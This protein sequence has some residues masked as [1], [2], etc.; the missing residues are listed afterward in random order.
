M[1]LRP[2]HAAGSAGMLALLCVPALSQGFVDR[3]GDV[4]LLHERATGFDRLGTTIIFD[5]LQRGIAL[6]DIDGDDDLDVVCCG[7]VLENT[8]LRNDGGVFTDVSGAAGIEVGELD[9]APALADFDGDGDLDLAIGVVE[10][11]GGLAAVPGANRFYRNDG[12]GVFEEITTLTATVGGGHTVAHLWSDLDRDGLLDLLASEMFG[13][14]NLVYRN[15][16]DG[17]F[18]EVGAS[19]GLDAA[20]MTHVTGLLDVD[21][22]G[23]DD[24]L[25]GNDFIAGNW[26]LLPTNTGDLHLRGRSDGTWLDVSAGSGADLA[27]G[28]RGIAI[29][30]VDYDGAMDVYKTDV[31][32]NHLLI[33]QGWPGGGAWLEQ[34]DF[35]G[36]AADLVPDPFAPPATGRAIGW[37]AVFMDF[38]FDL[39]LDLFL[40]NGQ[41]P[42]IHPTLQ[43]SPRGQ[44]NF[45]WTGDGPGSSFTFTDETAALGLLDEVDDRALAV[46]DVDDDGDVDILIGPTAGFLRYFENQIDPAGQGWL[47]VDPVCGTSAPGGF[48]VKARFTDSLGFVHE[49][50]IGQD[51]ATASQHASSAYF[52]LGNETSV[53]L[54]VEFPSGVTLSL[55]A[56]APN[57]AIAAVE[58]EIV[59]PNRR[60]MPIAAAGPAPP[61]VVGPARTLPVPFD[62]Q[63]A[64][65]VRVFAHDQA[66]NA[67]GDTAVVT[68]DVPG[69]VPLTPVT[70]VQGNEFLRLFSPPSTPGAFRAEVT[71]DGWTVGI[72]PRVHLFDPNDASG[73]TA[74]VV[75]T[76][77]RAASADTFTVTVAPKDAAGIALGPG[78]PLGFA[79]A[80]LTPLAGP[81][82]LGDGRYRATFPAP[83]AAGAHPIAVTLDDVP[84]GLGLEVEAAG[85]PD[86]AFTQLLVDVPNEALSASPHQLKLKAVPR[87][88]NGF[89]LGPAADVQIGVST[90]P[91]SAP[92]A[93]KT[94]T[95]PAGQPDGEFVFVLEKPLAFPPVSA[96]GSFTLTVEGVLLS[97]TPFAF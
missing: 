41:T 46:G 91:G 29:G 50:V 55:P 2:P 96:S 38:D 4:N 35:Y 43:F 8:V 17:T 67:L 25:V 94:G 3:T 82:D 84:L 88:V 6:G 22:D 1:S 10:S 80:G 49:R 39:W 77:V 74:R 13:G 16:G 14:P 93:L 28:I 18:S 15:N 21:G 59:R 42:G 20:G 71:I 65:E 44:R 60:T 36:V 53:D 92:V 90:D 58:P 27:R 52:G 79:V 95:F 7:G 23:W 54:E 5:W 57:Q 32:A 72:R 12:S 68:I 76:A 30:D 85:P 69:L 62:P 37:G 63:D 34:Q 83:A 73:T 97:T 78:R 75:P 64:Y 70:S 86:L 24:V 9:A 33:N 19:L 40:V 11:G 26:A 81:T 56:T 66:G 61:P 45:L 87:D 31:L 89:H 48:G 51:G 47:R